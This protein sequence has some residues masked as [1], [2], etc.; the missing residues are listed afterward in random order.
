MSYISTTYFFENF[1]NNKQREYGT[2]T[3]ENIFIPLRVENFDP[4]VPGAEDL[5]ETNNYGAVYCTGNKRNGSFF[6]FFGEK[7]WPGN[8]PKD[9]NQ[10]SCHQAT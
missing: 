7:D 8:A 9:C 1:Q 6:V 3:L 5:K 10:Y 4:R 2:I